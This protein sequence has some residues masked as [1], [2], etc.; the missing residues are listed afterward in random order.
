MVPLSLFRY[1]HVY[2]NVV[3]VVRTEITSVIN[4]PLITIYVSS[5]RGHELHDSRTDSQ[6]KKRRAQK[7]FLTPRVDSRPNVRFVSGNP[8]VFYPV[9]P[10]F[11]F[12]VLVKFIRIGLTP[13][14]CPVRR[15][16]RH[17]AHLFAVPSLVRLPLG[18]SRSPILERVLFGVLEPAPLAEPPLR[19]H[20]RDHVHRVEVH[21]QPL[22]NALLHRRLRAPPAPGSFHF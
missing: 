19:L 9:V 1:R 10:G 17:T 2:L 5:P 4:A 15:R 6:R 18:Q 7:H 8:R 3:Y 11:T 22:A 20:P 21:L 14:V 12:Y 16:A 13:T